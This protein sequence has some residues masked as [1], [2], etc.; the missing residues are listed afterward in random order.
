MFENILKLNLKFILDNKIVGGNIN[1][2]IDKLPFEMHYPGHNFT[3]PGTNIELKLEKN[4]KPVDKV[5]ENSLIHD[6]DYMHYK[7]NYNRKIADKELINRNNN[8]NTL[9]SKIV[10]TIMKI[11][12]LT[13]NGI[14]DDMINILD[15][16]NNFVNNNVNVKKHTRKNKKYIIS[17]KNKIYLEKLSKIY[18]FKIN[19]KVIS[20]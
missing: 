15:K 18:K 9:D 11:K 2:I 4:I 17:D 16:F 10:N 1:N 6:I 7:D 8:L 20:S 5:D 12:Q 14:Q 3:G 13:G 19:N